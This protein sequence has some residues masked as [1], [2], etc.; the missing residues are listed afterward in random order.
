MS[1]DLLE[2]LSATCLLT[3]TLKFMHTPLLFTFSITCYAG[4]RSVMRCSTFRIQSATWVSHLN[5]RGLFFFVYL[6]KRLVACEGEACRYI[7]VA[8]T[9]GSPVWVSKLRQQLWNS[10]GVENSDHSRCGSCG[11]RLHH[12]DSGHL[13]R[14]GVAGQVTLFAETFLPV[15][16]NSITWFY[17][18]SRNIHFIPLILK[19]S[20]YIRTL[21]VLH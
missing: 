4:A 21:A 18:H 17:W 6:S 9:L 5:F 16:T 14:A 20:S 13:L 11:T 1:V 10:Y 2:Y 19:I 15:K 12:E 7:A 8:I 3:Y